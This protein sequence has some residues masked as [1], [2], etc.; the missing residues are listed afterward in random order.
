MHK[1]QSAKQLLENDKAKPLT[2]DERGAMESLIKTS[3]EMLREDFL[4][5]R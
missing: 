3:K 1:S 4:R 5:Q 2:A